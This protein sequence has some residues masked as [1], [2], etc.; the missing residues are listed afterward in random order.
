MKENVQEETHLNDYLRVIFKRK[1]TIAAF[2]TITVAV[3]AV[4]TFTTVPVYMATTQ[5]LIEKETPNIVDFKELYAIDSSSQDF[6]KTQYS[7]LQSRLIAKM[8]MNNQ[9][10]K[11]RLSNPKNYGRGGLFRSRSDKS[12]D[13]L[14]DELMELFLDSLEVEPVRNTRLAR[15]SFKS[16]S[17]VL[18]AEVANTVVE[19]YSDH[20]L[21]GKVEAIH[22]ATDFLNEKIMEQRGKLEESELLLHKYKEE[23]KIV[24]LE[25]KEN[26]TV[27]NL[28]ELNSDVLKAEN[29]RVEAE[30]RYRQ[31][32]DL[33]N[34][35]D[36]IEA[37]PRVLSNTF[38]TRLKT[39]EAN[40]STELSELSK[41]YGPKHPRIV[42]LREKLNTTRINLRTEIKKVV[43][44]LKNE[45]EVALAK[46]K[47]LKK[48]LDELKAESQRLSELSI[49]YGVLK[50]DV[51]INK[52]MYEILLTRLKET[53]ITGG[54]Q[55]TSVKVIDR[56]EAPNVP[57]KPR[58]MLNFLLSVVFGL[59]GGVGIAF[60]M[61]H[62][63]NTIKTPDDIKRYLG[64]P[65]LGP[66]PN[67]TSEMRS[68]TLVTVDYPKSTASEA[69]RGVRTAIHFSSTQE[70]KRRTLLVTS[71]SPSEGKSLTASNLA[72]TM[73]QTGTRTLLVD[74]D[75]RKPFVHKLFGLTIESGCSNVLVGTAEL[76]D[77]IRKTDVP[78][79]EV[80]TC[81]H[82]PPNPAEL[83]GSEN[84]KKLIAELK[85][86]YE[87]VIFDSPPIS[88]VTD[89]VIIST[90]VDEVLLVLLAA[91]SS[92]T[93][94]L[95][96]VEQLRDVRAN[97]LGAV[98]NNVK[99]GRGSYYY[100]QYYD[101]PYGT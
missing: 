27:S 67:H 33:K 86:R 69:Y 42:T 30:M 9:N 23:F 90:A 44:F 94:A 35:P 91:S 4:I 18:A 26:I 89:P 49:A 31:A 8:V 19:S 52:Q 1:W 28:S 43:K 66:I 54:I 48:A 78:N 7:I 100:Y 97:L 80:I 56:A 83:L 36:M 60:F 81:G 38:I 5:I 59:F 24:S 21:K 74:A 14:E 95:R 63:D 75:F 64:I 82:I 92:R 79:L 77:V 88:L 39:D 55:S 13:Y 2:F 72:V 37:V 40:L 96:S 71:S 76:D 41:K 15:V 46:E 22:G 61:E 32:M 73:A 34:K 45:Y 29:D 17:P 87:R 99:S 47:T 84:M 85:S 93:I 12:S 98:I 65:F 3:I 16:T 10:L 53:G 62:L 70:E 6:Y 101:S 68:D 51:E 58:K 25:E 11:N 20:I 50:R 57:V